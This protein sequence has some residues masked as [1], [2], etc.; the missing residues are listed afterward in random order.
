MLSSPLKKLALLSVLAAAMLAIFTTPS[1]AG[2]WYHSGFWDCCSGYVS[3]RYPIYTVPARVWY[4][5]PCDDCCTDC[6]TSCCGSSFSVVTPSCCGGGAHAVEQPTLPPA[7]APKSQPE[8]KKDNGS[9]DDSVLQSKTGRLDRSGRPSQASAT[10][11]LKR[12][13]LAKSQP[14]QAGT[15]SAAFTMIVPTGAKVYVNGELTRTKGTQR[16]YVTEGLTPGLT[17]T[18]HIQAILESEGR[19][20]TDSQEVRVRAGDDLALDFDLSA[21]RVARK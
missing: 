19:R 15:G 20:W 10:S 14:E 6:C 5:V 7:K 1:Q 2:W 12:T 18:F 16:R 8:K 13:S 4:H 11:V 3:V 17:Y 21:E 9:G